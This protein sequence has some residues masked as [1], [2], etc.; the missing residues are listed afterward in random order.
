MSSSFHVEK[1]LFVNNMPIANGVQISP[2]IS[3]ITRI[4]LLGCTPIPRIP[5]K[6]SFPRIARITSIYNYVFIRVIR[7]D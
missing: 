7:G 6:K 2:R 4:Y 1:G 5:R 3:S